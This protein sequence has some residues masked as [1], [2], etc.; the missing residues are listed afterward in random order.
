VRNAVV[1]EGFQIYVDFK[2]IIFHSFSLQKC[3]SFMNIFCK[4][5]ARFEKAVLLRKVRAYLH[6]T[7]GFLSRIHEIYE[8]EL[9]GIL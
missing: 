5:G 4:S 6:V 9:C 8:A 7:I 1:K 2:C 3:A